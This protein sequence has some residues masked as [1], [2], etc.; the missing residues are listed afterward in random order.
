MTATNRLR[1]LRP[2]EIDAVQKERV[3]IYG[4]AGIGKTRLA[5]S[6]P[7]SWGK[8]AYYAAD[9]N[10]EFLQSISRSKRGRVV[11]ATQD[12]PDPTA[13]FMQFA[14]TD[15]KEIDEEI[16]VIIVDTYTKVAQDAIRYS[17]MSGAMSN[18]AHFI[19]GIPGQGGQA[20]PNRGDYLAIE[21]L[22]RGFLDMLFDR[23]R[24][25]HIILLCH[26]DV[27]IVEDVAA[28]GGPAHPGRA[29]TEYLPAQFSTVIRLIREEELIPGDDAATSVVIAITE[30]DGKFIAKMRVEDESA[31]NPMARV[32]LDR[33]PSSYWV[34]YLGDPDAPSDGIKQGKKKKKK[35]TT[36]EEE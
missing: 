23:Q 16:G 15:W 36:N 32:V 35:T 2:E 8:A 24:E 21:S 4:R 13:C 12:G 25:M 22:S 7:E 31:P 17:A 3:I 26:E 34:K 11:V 30:N 33:D 29:M 1:I 20:I 19:I 10:S 27:K 14:M 5:L 6:Y 9:K 18:E 28:V